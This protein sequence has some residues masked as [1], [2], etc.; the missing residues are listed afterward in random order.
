[1]AV[2]SGNYFDWLWELK[3]HWLWG[4]SRFSEGFDWL[5]N[6]WVLGATL[7]L[8]LAPNQNV[9][10]S[11]NFWRSIL[12]LANFGKTFFQ[13]ANTTKKSG[14]CN[15]YQLIAVSVC[16][17]RASPCHNNNALFIRET[18]VISNAHLSNISVVSLL[19]FLGPRLANAMICFCLFSALFFFV[20]N[21]LMPN[22]C[23]CFV[24]FG[25]PLFEYLW[26]VLWYF[27]VNVY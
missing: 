3:I 11:G 10:K 24:I 12:S 2:G 9:K 7:P 25:I 4:N 21:F 6:D 5:W 23:C 22:C 1:M 16:S 8:Y 19:S 18:G 15:G 27:Y 14:N 13:L 20:Y 17:S 26:S